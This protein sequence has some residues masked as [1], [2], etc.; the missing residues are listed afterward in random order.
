MLGFSPISSAP[1]SDTG[2]TIVVFYWSGNADGTS[3]ADGGY[4]GLFYWSGNSA[5]ISEAAGGYMGLFL[6]T[7]NSQGTSLGDWV[8]LL[9]LESPF[10]H[11]PYSPQEEEMAIL[12]NYAMVTSEVRTSS[13]SSTGVDT[14]GHNFGLSKQG[15]A[16][17]AAFYLTVTAKTGTAPTLD[18]VIEDSPDAITYTQVGAFTQLSDAVGNERK[19]FEGPFQRYMRVRWTIG[20]ADTP[21][22]TF[23]VDAVFQE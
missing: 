7:G 23:K 12:R 20:G 6:W 19:L 13:S 17:L 1:L 11:E 18:V 8:N 15:L 22:F 16:R 21:G 4:V 14:Q 10:E 9:A 3:E 5:G 2:A